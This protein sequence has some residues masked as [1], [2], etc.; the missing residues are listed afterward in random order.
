[1]CVRVCVCACV[2]GE[3]VNPRSV[4]LILDRKNSSGGKRKTDTDACHIGKRLSLTYL[5]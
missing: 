4:E 5:Y 2:S 1:M 3:S